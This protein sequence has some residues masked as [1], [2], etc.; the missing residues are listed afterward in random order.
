MQTPG[1]EFQAPLETM[2]PVNDAA[3]MA[4]WSKFGRQAGGEA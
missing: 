3:G 4:S 1:S 2:L